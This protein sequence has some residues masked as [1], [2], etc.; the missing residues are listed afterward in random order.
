M[1]GQSGPR[2]AVASGSCPACEEV[3]RLQATKNLTDDQVRDLLHLRRLF[4][5]R[6][7]QLM[8]ERKWLL[9]QVSDIGDSSP[10]GV[11]SLDQL[12][13]QLKLNGAL[14]YNAYTQFAS[15]FFRGVSLETLSPSH[16]LW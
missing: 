5:G 13:Q 8:R 2:C 6:M 7:G 14:E 9:S 11:P 16:K 3:R 12:A 15:T 4:Y 10:T 1:W